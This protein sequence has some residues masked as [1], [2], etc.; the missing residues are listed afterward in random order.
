M[1]VLM[2]ATVFPRPDARTAGSYNTE[3]VVAHRAIGSTVAAVAPVHRYGPV[4]TAAGRVLG[5]SPARVAPGSVFAEVRTRV[6]PLEYA[7]LRREHA[8]PRLVARTAEDI[9]RAAGTDFDVVHAHGMYVPAAG[10][11]AAGVSARTGIPYVVTLHGSDINVHMPRNRERY[12]HVLHGARTVIS[13]SSALRRRAVE[14]GGPHTNHVVIPNGVDTEV[15]HARERAGGGGGR[16]VV[17]FAGNLLRIKGADRLPAIFRAVVELVGPARFRV[18]GLGPLHGHIVS[19]GAGLD[20]EML[21]ELSRQGVA[22]LFRGADLVVLPSRSEGW[23]TVILESHAT[24]T[25]V[26]AAD[27]GG[28]AE[29]VGDPRFVVAP[30]E[31]FE[32]RFAERAAQILSGE[33]RAAGLAERGAR[34][35]WRRI[36]E[37]EAAAYRGPALEGLTSTRPGA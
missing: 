7:S 29:A 30:G 15:F 19:G 11:L 24:G 14:L 18:A 27:V 21:G 2:I 16:P 8:A 31:G 22:D 37:L 25:P 23:P 35:S 13:V 28:C 33:V 6:G 5:R 26:L 9:C 4:A 3:R 12:A 32:R 17:V 10:L 20:V 1:R 36:A 34:H